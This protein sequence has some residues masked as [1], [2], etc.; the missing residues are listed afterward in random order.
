MDT[1][2]QIIG[3]MNK[4]DIRFYKLFASRTNTGEDRKDLLLFDLVRDTVKGGQNEE[5]VFRAL[6]GKQKDKN[7]FYRLKNHLMEEVCKSNFILHVKDDDTIYCY[8]ILCQFRYFFTR[9][10]YKLALYFLKRAE[11]QASSI[12]DLEILD[13]VYS[14]FVKLSHELLSVNPERYLSERRKIW[15]KLTRLRQMDSILTA[16]TFRLK[17]SQNYLSGDTDILSILETTIDDFLTDEA[18]RQDPAFRI[19]IYEAVSQVLLQKHEYRSLEDYLEATWESFTK[20]KVFNRHTH[21]IKL[22]MLTYLANTYFKNSKHKQSLEAAA[23]LKAALDEYNGVYRDKYQFF[24]FNALVINYSV[25]NPDKA[26]EILENLNT[27]EAIKRESY[28]QVFIN[29][30]LAILWHDKGNYRNA[31]KFLTRLMLLETF[32]ALDSALKV[33]IAIVELMIR[34]ALPDEDYLEVRLKQIKKEHM[35]ILSKDEFE[36]EKMLVDIIAQLIQGKPKIPKKI[37]S[38]FLRAKRPGS[39]ETELIN[40]DRWLV[41]VTG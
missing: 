41:S 39:D 7:A 5:Q 8:Y 2:Q 13:I 16:I 6:Y 4:E 29:L 12:N 33:K 20:D 35:K 27:N 11:K 36:R 22:Q 25:L 31:I 10:E 17:K 9:N 24:Y 28:F 21:N 23:R 30:N 37:I 38:N 15:D 18:I 34:S 32:P 40:Y 1:L 14:E 19:K 26:I 3:S